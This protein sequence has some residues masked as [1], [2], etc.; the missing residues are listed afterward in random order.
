M[1]R[2]GKL[3]KDYDQGQL[4]L[5]PPS[6]E[7]MIDKNHPVRVVNQVLDSIDIDVLINKY[8]G[9]GTTSYHPR[10]MLKVMVYAYISN[11]YSSRM[12]EAAL[13][14]N[15]HFMWLAGMN[16]PDHNSINRFRSERLKDV[17][18]EVFTKVVLMLSESG[19]LS[20]KDVY[21]DGTKIE[22]SANKYTF[23][24][25][26]NIQ[27]SRNNIQS[28]LGTLWGVSLPSIINFF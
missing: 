21:T 5:L 14:E 12:I 28:Q 20:L 8:K 16:R 25:R 22:S 10:M 24:W 13:K 18:K 3:F 2:H 15:L 23:V 26:K 4:F 17:L 7:D 27:N 6:I 9:G 1:K 11:V 19:H